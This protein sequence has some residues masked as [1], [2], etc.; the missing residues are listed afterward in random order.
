MQIIKNTSPEMQ[1]IWHFGMPFGASA[2]C[3]IFLESS[4]HEQNLPTK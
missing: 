2:Q 3:H 1:H 4:F